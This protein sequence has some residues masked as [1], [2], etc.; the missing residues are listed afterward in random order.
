MVDCWA[1]IPTCKNTGNISSAAPFHWRTIDQSFLRRQLE[2]PARWFLRKVTDGT[3]VEPDGQ[4][5]DEYI[6]AFFGS[7]HM[8]VS[9]TLPAA[10][11]EQIP[12]LRKAQV[13]D[14]YRIFRE[15]H[16]YGLR[17]DS[18]DRFF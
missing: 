2:N 3:L 5:L 17:N 1:D 10:W 9:M 18:F 14:Q 6:S 7:Q 12:K 8:D 11:D 16:L 4:R 13:G 15:M